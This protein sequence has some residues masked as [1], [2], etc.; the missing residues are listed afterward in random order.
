[1]VKVDIRIFWFVSILR[2]TTRMEPK[3]VLLPGLTCWIYCVGQAELCRCACG[4]RDD[5]RRPSRRR[6][7][8]VAD[9]HRF[10]RWFNITLYRARNCRSKNRRNAEVV[11]G[12]YAWSHAISLSCV[13]LG[14]EIQGWIRA[15]RGLRSWIF[16]RCCRLCEQCVLVKIHT[17][18]LRVRIVHALR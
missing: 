16:F 18:S 1:M 9:A 3:R 17:Y 4:R 8:S 13:P 14:D 10:L 2:N 11:V 5:D 15:P 12:N 7:G 6:R